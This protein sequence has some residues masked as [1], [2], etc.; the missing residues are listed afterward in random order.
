MEFDADGIDSNCAPEE[1]PG[2]PVTP[3]SDCD[4]C[5]IATAAFGSAFR[6]KIDVLK[7]F[8]DEYLMTH[9]L[10]KAF[11]NAY[12]T[13]SPPVADFIAARPWLRGI[14]R[15][16]LLPLVGFASLII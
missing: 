16:L 4:D 8:R 2:G 5:F 9:V 3:G 6:G 1:C 14:V 10:G 12:Y 15:V 7:S 11:V 13:Y